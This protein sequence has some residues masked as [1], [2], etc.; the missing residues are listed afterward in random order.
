MGVIRCFRHAES[1]LGDF[2]IYA[3]ALDTPLS[4]KGVEHVINE[5]LNFSYDEL[6]YDIVFTSKQI[7]AIQT[8]CIFLSNAMP[9][10]STILFKTATE[11]SRVQKKLKCDFLPII[12]YKELN[13]RNYGILEGLTKNEAIERYGEN[14]IFRWRRD[15][16]SGAPEGENFTE[17]VKRVDKFLK[18][19]LIKHMRQNKNILIVA[20]QNSLRALYYLLMNIN[21]EQI[22]HTNF[23]NFKMFEF[24]YDSANASIISCGKSNNSAKT[25]EGD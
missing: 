12:T 11:Y 18:N 7:R 17:V 14:Q 9:K 16:Y 10:Q 19:V 3:G 13:E 23:E 5:S 6:I 20:H 2:A 24:I 21:L 25:I 4:K 8:A 22:Q 15:F 1:V